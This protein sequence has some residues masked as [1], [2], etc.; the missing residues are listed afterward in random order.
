[1]DSTSSAPGVIQHI[2][3]AISPARRLI[4]RLPMKYSTTEVSSHE[5]VLSNFKGMT[6]A[7][8]R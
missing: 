3:A 2:A 1:M 6:F 4:R 5:S 7:P 8:N